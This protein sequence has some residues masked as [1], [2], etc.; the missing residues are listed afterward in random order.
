MSKKK[1]KQEELMRTHVLNL[2]EIREAERTDTT[3]RRKKLPI[4]F[5]I[6]G[7]L[8][9]MTGIG[10]SIAFKNISNERV[11]NKLANETKNILTCISNSKDQ[12]YNVL[13]HTET[14]YNFENNKLT[15]SQT[16]STTKTVNY[17]DSVALATVQNNLVAYT[18]Q[19][20]I[21]SGQKNNISFSTDINNNHLDITYNIDYT[22]QESF[23]SNRSLNSFLKIPTVGN[24]NSYNE[25]KTQ[26]EK[27]GALCN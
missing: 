21:A 22:N 2:T 5:S 1:A 11:T 25:V 26:S 27:L 23:D 12:T 14:V 19:A 20:E 8:C 15:S 16:T 4:I 9:I 24:E 13:I 6:I 7:I 3:K 17:N 10:T 18:S